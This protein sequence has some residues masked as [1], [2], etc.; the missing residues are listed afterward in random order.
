MSW[1]FRKSFGFGPFRSTFSQKGMGNSI[2]FFG[3]RFGV[4]PDGRKY[5]SFGI[6]GTGFYYIKYF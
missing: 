6:R 5:F 3:F 2:G 1:R 4:T